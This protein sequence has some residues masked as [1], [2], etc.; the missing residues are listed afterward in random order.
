M[1]EECKAGQPIALESVLILTDHKTITVICV[2]R[3]TEKQKKANT[4]R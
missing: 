1:E 2:I 4:F 3:K